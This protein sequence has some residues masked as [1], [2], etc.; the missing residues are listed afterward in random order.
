MNFTYITE[1]NSCLPSS[2][3]YALYILSIFNLVIKIFRLQV[4]TVSTRVIYRFLSC[5]NKTILMVF[6][7][8]AI[9]AEAD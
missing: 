4:D 5:L 6:I 8:K 2:M 1:V 7:M 3:H 9:L